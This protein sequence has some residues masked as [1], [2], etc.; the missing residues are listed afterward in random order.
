MAGGTGAE[1]DGRFGAHR[2]T[3]A[4]RRRRRPGARAARRAGPARGRRRRSHRARRRRDPARRRRRGRLGG[5]RRAGPPGRAAGRRRAGRAPDAAPR[6]GS[7]RRR[8]ARGPA[9]RGPGAAALEPGRPRCS[10][11]GW[12]PAAAAWASRGPTST[13]RRCSARSTSHPRAVAPT[14]SG[15]TS[16]P[17]CGRWCR[18]SCPAA[19]TTW[20]PERVEVPSGS[21]LRVDYADPDAPAL[22]VRVQEVFG[23][24]DAAPRGR[25]AAAA[26]P[27]LP[28][29]PGRG[30][31]ERPRLVLD[32]RLS[33]PSER[34]CAAATPGTPGPRIPAAA[35]PSRR[36]SPRR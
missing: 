27:A 34:S 24:R 29:R 13:T 1:L 30:R 16:S 23:W 9:P 17:P 15:S 14:C 19:S 10:G 4:R 18:G 6:P 12:R 2:V 3:L 5:R 35:R 20:R 25:A 31:D 28:R 26:A 21:R 36:P 7:R 8:A 33:R 32:D 11:S 22:P